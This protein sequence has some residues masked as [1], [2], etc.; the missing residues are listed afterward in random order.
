M[1]LIL[2]VDDYKFYADSTDEEMLNYKS[3]EH[4]SE[5]DAREE[6]YRRN[7]NAI[8]EEVRKSGKVLDRV[9]RGFF[10]H[11]GHLHNHFV[12]LASGVDDL[13]DRISLNWA[14]QLQYMEAFLKKTDRKKIF[15]ER[16][17]QVE[18]KVMTDYSG[19]DVFKQVSI[20]RFLAEMMDKD[21]RAF[22]LF[23]AEDP[24]TDGPF[25]KVVELI[26]R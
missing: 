21:G 4:I 26:D 2:G 1:M 11:P 23:E 22:F 12:Y 25:I 24:V 8:C 20:V 6:V 10:S 13:K 14:S 17:F 19:V 3:T 5:F 18:E 15:A 7:R 9:V 16:I